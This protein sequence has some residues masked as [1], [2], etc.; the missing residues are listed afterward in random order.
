VLAPPGKE[1]VSL[2][3]RLDKH[4]DPTVLRPN[5][6]GEVV[7]DARFVRDFGPTLFDCI[8]DPTVDADSDAAYVRSLGKALRKA[9]RLYD[10]GLAKHDSRYELTTE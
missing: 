9:D 8:F 5:T 6:R 2:A 4:S 7:A 1:P 3:F 10:S